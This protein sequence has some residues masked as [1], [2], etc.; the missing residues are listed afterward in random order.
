M[1]SQQTC[2]ASDRL[3]IAMQGIGAHSRGHAAWE[4]AR[5]ERELVTS[6]RLTAAEY[7]LVREGVQIGR[8]LADAGLEFDANTF[9]TL[10]VLESSIAEN[11]DLAHALGSAVLRG[12]IERSAA[13]TS[14][15][16]AAEAGT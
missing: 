11:L 7:A 15:I 1:L 2:S 10:R 12:L 3:I 16:L 14:G 4:R 8:A 5:Q 13:L 6:H 9:V